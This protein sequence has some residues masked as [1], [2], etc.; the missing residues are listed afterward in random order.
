MKYTKHW[1]TRY[2]GPLSGGMRAHSTEIYLWILC[3]L[4]LFHSCIWIS[5][6]IEQ[7]THFLILFLRPFVIKLSR[8]LAFYMKNIKSVCLVHYWLHSVRLVFERTKHNLLHRVFEEKSPS[9][10]VSARIRVCLWPSIEG[11]NITILYRFD[12]FFFNEQFDWGFFQRPLLQV[13][14]CFIDGLISGKSEK[15]WNLISK[16]FCVYA[17][18]SRPVWMWLNEE[19]K[20]KR[21]KIFKIVLST[22][23]GLNGL[24]L[25]DCVEP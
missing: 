4:S 21:K 10:S 2:I 22:K 12:P 5:C 7:I 25:C 1:Y 18:D 15:S 8:L 14:H 19:Q 3:N 24:S 23:T 6:I 9:Q 13:V 11:N 16:M 20:K 17:F